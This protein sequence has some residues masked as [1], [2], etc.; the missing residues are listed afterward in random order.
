[1]NVPHHPSGLML[2]TAAF[3]FA[4]RKHV[5][6]RRKGIAAE[7]YLNHLTEVAHLLA[8]ATGGADPVLVAAGVLHDVLE[9]T[10]TT[11]DELARLFGAEV[12]DLVREVTSDKS[13]ARADRKRLQLE[14]ASTKSTR[15][16]LIKL[17]DKTSNARALASSPPADWPPARRQE[18][19][20]WARAVVAGCRGVS[21]FL[22]ARF[23][24][25]CEEGSRALA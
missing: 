17:A 5:D 16:R 22:E 19:L 10:A 6:H 23:D 7:P 8:E 20:D 3:D 15:A 25:A 4:A 2:V 21:P 24:A 9:D 11:A 18:Y 13:L 14:A 12:A 1:M